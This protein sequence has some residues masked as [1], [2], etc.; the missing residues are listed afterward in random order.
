MFSPV[1]VMECS[2]TYLALNPLAYSGPAPPSRHCNR[3]RIPW[4]YRIVDSHHP[5]LL[6]FR[7]RG[8]TLDHMWGA[9]SSQTFPLDLCHL[10]NF[11]LHKGPR[12][13]TA[14]VSLFDV[15]KREASCFE[16]GCICGG[17]YRPERY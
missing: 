1:V 7:D 14:M 5:V 17:R 6:C 15:G 3:S 2:N 11:G 9:R 12:G 8:S 13:P 4:Y 10:V 16:V